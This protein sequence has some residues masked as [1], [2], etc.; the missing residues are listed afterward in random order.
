MTP[1]MEKIGAHPATAVYIGIL[2]PGSTS[3]M[4]A[5]WLRRITPAWKWQWIDT[6]PPLEESARLWRSLAYRYQAGRAVSAIN[7]KVSADVP[8]SADLVWVDKAVFLNRNTMARVRKSAKRL[9]HFT[10]DTAFGA[11]SSRHFEASL[12]LFD[13]AITTKSFEIDQY[14]SRISDDRIFLTTQG[15]DPD[16][17]FPRFGNESRRR[18]AAFVGLAEPDREKCVATLIAHGIPV[19]LAGRGWTAFVQRFAGNPLLAFDGEDCFGSDYAELLS[20]SWMGLGLL[21]KR[22]AELHTTRTF[23]IPACGAILATETTAET[24]KFFASTD[25][26]F[27]KDHEQLAKAAKELLS[28]SDQELATLAA[29][30][31]ARV[32]AGHRDYP[33]ILS[34]ALTHPRLRIGS[35]ES[36]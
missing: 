30:G 3:R 26:L 16:V 7:N 24:T 14:K 12:P 2:T 25:A 21:S 33:S 28:R 27:F 20:R 18:E 22:F 9:A 31:R 4:R 32:I 34:A 35:G 6:D 17:H 36:L 5:E 15:F 13:L 10:P 23:E 11:N 8:I 1:E 29:S 19:R